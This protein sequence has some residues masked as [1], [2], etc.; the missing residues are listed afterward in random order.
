MTGCGPRVLGNRG[1]LNSPSSCRHIQRAISQQHW[2]LVEILPASNAVSSPLLS[3]VVRS[4]A[5]R[6]VLLSV[7][8]LMSFAYLSGCST[9]RLLARA[10][11]DQLAAEADD[12]EEDLEL[13]RD[14]A[15]FF[16][17]FSESVLA[18]TPDHVALA[19]TVAA[20]F[21][22][23]AWA[24]VAFEADRIEHS[25]SK[26]AA[27][28]RQ[29]AVKLYAR[30]E[31]HAMR[32]LEHHYPGIGQRLAESSWPR[33][34]QEIAPRH[35]GLAYWAAAA[36]GARIS[37]SK[38]DAE[39]LAQ[40]PAAMRL[41]TRLTACCLTWGD[42]AIAA[43]A[44]NFEAGRPGG[45]SEDARRW[46]DEATRLSGGRK[47]AVPLARAEALSLPAGDREEFV[48]LVRESVAIAS[49]YPGADN[50]IMLDRARWLLDTVDDRF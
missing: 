45:R 32:A 43:L 5:L 42:G 13:A 27:R 7:L 10:V 18:Q 17:K 37:L 3:S 28:L 11:A 36:W 39:S 16:L 4:P 46:F 8:A 31:G 30:A 50:R 40:L 26:A 44:G 9:N 49:R 14:A 24:F 29:R 47:A 21:V 22:R 25:D 34:S 33:E 48:R 41:V 35:A 38:S 1:C 2:L 15:P 19:E 12:K 20:G 23:Y 6:V